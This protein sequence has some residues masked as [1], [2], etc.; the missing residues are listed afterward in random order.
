MRKC[1]S[2]IGIN[3]KRKTIG[4]FDDEVEAAVSYDLRAME[5]LGEFAY[6]NFTELMQRYKL[7]NSIDPWGASG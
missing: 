3:G 7:L 6:F 1:T 5:V 2:Q 4:Y